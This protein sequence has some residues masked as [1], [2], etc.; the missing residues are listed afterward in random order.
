MKLNCI[1]VDDEP[2]ARKLLEEYCHQFAID[3]NLNDAEWLLFDDLLKTRPSQKVE[4]AFAAIQPDTIAKILFTSGSTGLPKGVINTHEN[5]STNWQQ[6]TQTFPFMEEEGLEFIDWLPWN[7]TF[8]GNHN[9]GL[10]I[11]N[12]GSLYIDDGN[13]TPQ[14]IST[15]VAN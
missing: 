15:T 12:G 13:P 11:Y 8:G 9:F 2:V 5:I 4:D 10:T 6:I 3:F 7:H 1:I 14:G